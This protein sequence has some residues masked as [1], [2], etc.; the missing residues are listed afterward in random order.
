[1]LLEFLTIAFLSSGTNVIPYDAQICEKI[2]SGEIETQKF[3]NLEN[4]QLILV[5]KK[6]SFIRVLSIRE[7]NNLIKF[8]KILPS[9]AKFVFWVVMLSPSSNIINLRN[10]KKISKEKMPILSKET[11][12]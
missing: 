4:N 10:F 5:A 7:M 1:M 6:C 2:A 8:Y 11:K 3:S 9:E 12:I